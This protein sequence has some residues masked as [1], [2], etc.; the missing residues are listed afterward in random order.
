MF[1]VTK[2]G[3]KVAD[4]IKF[5]NQL[6]QRWGGYQ[7]YP[8]VAN[9]ITGVLIKWER[10]AEESVLEWWCL[11]KARTAI[12]GF[13]RKAIRQ[14]RHMPRNVGRLR[15]LEHTGNG[16]YSRTSTKKCSPADTF[17]LTRW[18]PFQTSDLQNCKIHISVVLATTFLVFCYSSNRK[19]Y[20]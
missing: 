17:I 15:K 12:A 16:F 6:T 8:G 4:G 9:V 14:K 13:P 19:L 3:N 5:A 20:N 2:K 10:D 7:D 18:D 1:Y 11:R